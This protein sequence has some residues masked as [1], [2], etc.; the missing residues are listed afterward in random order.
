M[1]TP[2]RW[3]RAAALTAAA[4]LLTP[5]L[6]AA[7][8]PA[9]ASAATTQTTLRPGVVSLS[10]AEIANPM[11]GQYRWMG[12]NSQP[13]DWPTTD[14]YYRDQ[15]YWGR[16][17]PQRGQYDF[18]HLETGLANAASTSGKFGFR[19]M[20][21]CPG[22]WMEKRN[23]ADWP[24]VTPSFLPRQPGTEIPDWNSETFLSAWEDLMAELGRRYADDPRLGYVDVGGFGKYGEWMP[25]G[26]DITASN[27]MRLIGAVASAFPEKHVLLS[28]VPMWTKR[29][30]ITGSAVSAYSNLGLRS[31]CLGQKDMQ[32]P[33]TAFLDLWKTRPFFT[34][35]C[36]GGDPTIAEDQVSKFHVSTI[37]SGNLRLT[38][39]AMTSAQ[40]SAYQR[41]TKASGYR[42]AVT[43]ATF[44]GIAPGK[45][46]TAS[47]TLSNAGTAPTYERWTTRLV[48]RDSSGGRVATLPLSLDLRTRLPGSSTF[49]QTLTAPELPEGSYTAALEV[50]DPEGYLPPMRLANTS[51]DIEGAYP[52]GSVPVGHSEPSESSEPAVLRLSGSDRYA[53]S[54][55]ISAET[56]LPGVPVA[57]VATGSK[58]PDALSGAPAAGV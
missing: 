26:T 24:R 27:A 21:Y 6:V 43:Q 9:G 20:A 29:P 22:C 16:I 40:K 46:F 14:A 55:A 37:S 28:A 25:A 57:Y 48:L 11:R 53:A 12:Q 8:G 51:R 23:T 47:L 30:D 50:V 2:A 19:V 10:A 13:G 17:E 18:R 58:F 1:R 42:Y 49:S 4:S 34:E 33:T 45:P 38:Y 7:V 52:L 44:S 15:V 32:I 35:W 36:T 41:A 5:A 54:A 56:F 31:D 39:D 3:L